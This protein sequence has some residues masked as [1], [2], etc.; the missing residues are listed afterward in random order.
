MALSTYGTLTNEQRSFYEGV[1]ITRTLPFLP[2][3]R[4]GQKGTVPKNSGLVVEWRKFAAFALATSAL[5]EGT[6]PTENDLTITKVTATIAQYGA[7]SKESDLLIV[8][9][10]D[11]VLTEVIG[12]HGEQ[13]GQS[14]HSLLMTQLASGSSVRYASTATSRVTVAA[15]MNATLADV[16]KVV[17]DLRVNNAMPYPD[18]FYHG[19]IHPKQEYDLMA[20]TAAGEWIDVNKYVGNEPLL[21]GEIGRAAGVRFMRSTQAPVFTGAG[22]G[23]IDVYAALIYGPGAWGQRDLSTQTTG[24]VDPDT[25]KGAAQVHVIPADADDKSDPLHQYGTAGYKFATVF[26]VLDSAKIIRLE[27]AASA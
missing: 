1:L 23:G 21:A 7:W 13:A 11:P 2:T 26:K 10:I 17:R 6:P 5:T 12:L 22:A 9:G 14:L 20:N 27:T 15:G 18:G 3:L 25:N 8:A 16:R 19:L 4:D 24:A